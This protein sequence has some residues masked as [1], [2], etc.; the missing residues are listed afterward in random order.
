MTSPNLFNSPLFQQM[1]PNFMS[2]PSSNA[3]RPLPLHLLQAMLYVQSWPAALTTS[4]SAWSSARPNWNSSAASN[5]AADS[6]FNPTSLM[7][8]SARL[9]A[10]EFTAWC[11]G[12]NAYMEAMRP[13]APPPA[14]IIWQ[15]GSTVVRDYAGPADAPLVVV[16][17][18]LINRATILDLLP[19]RSLLRYLAQRSGVRLVDW[20]APGADE[21]DFALDDYI[22]RLLA[23]VQQAQ[24]TGRPVY[25]MGYCMGGLLA[26]AAAQALSQPVDGLVLMATPWDF[27]AYPPGV[28][29]GLQQWHMGLQPWLATGETVPVDILQTL[30][31]LMQP[32][33]AFEKFKRVG[34][35]G[36]DDLFIATEDWLNDGVPLVAKVAGTCFGD[37]FANNTTANGAWQVMGQTVAPATIT[38][39]TFVI[40]PQ[41]DQLVPPPCALA[42]ADALP[43]ARRLTPDL[44]H[45]GMIVGRHAQTEV[46]D[47]IA[48]FISS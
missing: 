40:A 7:A 2:S 17:P 48:A 32:L 11:K 46:W 3:P 35:Q 21:R 44:G 27:S 41:R 22:A 20:Q 31:A 33:A 13:L 5:S 45:V 10:D 4:M 8:A 23:V 25:L 37:W 26:L 19:D 14:R 18:S 38:T 15:Q 12:V 47:K 43:N 9:A 39:P 29:A 42:L 34:T 36:Y 28:R 1:F 6:N 16:V 30:F 24:A